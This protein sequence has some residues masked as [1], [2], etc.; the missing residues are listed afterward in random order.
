VNSDSAQSRIQQPGHF[1][2]A[3]TQNILQSRIRPKPHTDPT[4]SPQLHLPRT[5]SAD[6]GHTHR[7]S[8][9]PHHITYAAN[10]VDS[11]SQTTEVHRPDHITSPHKCA[12]AHAHTEQVARATCVSHN[13]APLPNS[14]TCTVDAHQGPRQHRP[15]CP[16]AGVHERAH[17]DR[18]RRVWTVV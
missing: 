5:T 4:A 18:S 3:R 10:A 14:I 8:V 13:S 17:K 11:S 9:P 12:S 1:H 16:S 2:R 6:P 7:I 15:C